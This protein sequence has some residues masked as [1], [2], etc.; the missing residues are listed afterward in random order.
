[1]AGKAVSVEKPTTKTV[2]VGG[3]K[4]GGERVVPINHAVRYEGKRL[5]EKKRI[6]RDGGCLK[7]AGAVCVC[8]CVLR[9]EGPTYA[10]TSL[11]R[12]L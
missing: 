8:V 7:R 2:K 11:K 4:N 10:R 5:R 12:G 6:R 3:A 1:M 9:A